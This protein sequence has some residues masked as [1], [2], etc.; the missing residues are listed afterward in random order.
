MTITK[1]EMPENLEATGYCLF[2]KSLEDDQLVLFHATPMTNFAAIDA[3][4]FKIPNPGGTAGGGLESVSFAKR[5]SASLTH[6]MT[7]R[8]TCPGDYCVFAVRYEKFDQPGI[9]VNTSDIHD[10]KLDPPPE[11]I[12]YCIIP[13]AYVHR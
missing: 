13:A 9:V 7:K 11:I 3:D 10:Y 1:Y 2:P 8:Q 12:G 5:S 4:G 6:A